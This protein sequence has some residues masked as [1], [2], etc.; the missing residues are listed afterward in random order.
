MSAKPNKKLQKLVFD[1][2]HLKGLFDTKILNCNVSYRMK[3][4]G[5]A[6]LALALVHLGEVLLNLWPQDFVRNVAHEGVSHRV[7]TH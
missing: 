5:D 4:K 6:V 3:S 1:S 2:E 7:G